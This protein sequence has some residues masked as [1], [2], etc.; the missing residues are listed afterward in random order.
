LGQ[1]TGLGLSTVISIIR[2]HGGFVNVY[3]EVGQG[4]QFKVYLPA[5][6]D[7]ETRLVEN[8]EQFFGNGELILV[9]DDEPTICEIT[10]TSLEASGYTVLTA[11]DGIEAV[12]LY[13]EHK[14]KVDTVLMDM[15]MPNMAGP[16]AIQILKKM[17]P[18][19]KIVAVSGLPSSEK[20][21]EAMNMGATTFLSKPYTSQELLK[22]LH[23]VLQQGVSQ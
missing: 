15:M 4:T 9:V 23:M 19:V 14:N 17:N 12:A 21:E 2:S 10:K 16:A 1:G 5:I 20:V 22:T 7:M 3:S 6:E 8:S 11:N 18:L 13:A